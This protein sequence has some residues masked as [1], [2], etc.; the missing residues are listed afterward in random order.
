MDGVDKHVEDQDQTPLMIVSGTFS[1]AACRW[2]IVQKEADVIVETLRH[3]DYLLH[4]PGGFDLYTDHVNLKF[5]FNPASINAA[6]SKYTAANSDRSALLLM[7][8]DYRIRDIAGDANVWADL[9]STW[10]STPP[11]C[12]TF[13]VPLKAAPLEDPNSYG[14]HSR[15]S[16]SSRKQRCEKE[17]T[18]VDAAGR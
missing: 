8:Y 3:S 16:S 9:L 11:I 1:G 12:A 18:T 13:W 15:I 14:R 5:I 6:V 17:P 7:G 2:A 10:G 4:R